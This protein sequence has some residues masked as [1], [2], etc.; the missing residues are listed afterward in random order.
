M[1]V[2]VGLGPAGQSATLLHRPNATQ[3]ERLLLIDRQKLMDI[4][5][6]LT[7]TFLKVLVLLV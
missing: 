3:W 7:C 5:I 1:R 4:L 6:R 2:T